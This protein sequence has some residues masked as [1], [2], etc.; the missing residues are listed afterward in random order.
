LCASRR[1]DFSCIFN[2]IIAS[3]GVKQDSETLETR[4]MVYGSHIAQVF[5]YSLKAC[6][7]NQACV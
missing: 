2:E 7:E 4:Y 5:C 3:T 1:I 6:V